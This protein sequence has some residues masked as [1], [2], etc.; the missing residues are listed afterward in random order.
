MFLDSHCHLFDSSFDEDRD[1]ILA[2]ADEAGLR[3]LLTMGTNP[4]EMEQ[5]LALAEEHDHIYVSAGLH[6]HEAEDFTEELYQQFLAGYSHP[7]MI[8]VG[9]IGLDFWY[10]NSPRDQQEEVF[11]RY[12]R[13]ALEID[14]PVII[15][16]RDPKNGPASASQAYSRIMAEEDPENRLRGIIHCFS[17]SYQF[18]EENIERGFLISF[19][20]IA[21]FP[22]ASELRDV[23]RR[24]PA[25]NILVETDC[26][27]LAPVPHRGKRNEPSF[28]VETA[29]TI[30]DAR[31]ISHE[32]MDRI[33]TENFERLFRIKAR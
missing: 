8:G 19:P 18:A 28:V 24:I 25:E 1:A 22:K 14:K 11:R 31:G 10:D 17:H 5:S 15:H 21:T 20:G 32:T 13:L 6:P 29:K 23:A 9:E 30:A 16:L 2:R 33:V 7:K 27:Y 3:Y 12:L 26:P 4:L